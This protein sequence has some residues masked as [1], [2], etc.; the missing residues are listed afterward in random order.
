MKNARPVAIFT[1]LIAA[2]ALLLG[3]VHAQSPTELEW[4]V[5]KFWPE[6]DDPRLLV[7]ID[8]KLANPGDELRLPIPQEAQLNAVAAADDTGR[9]LT[10]DWREE[11]GP[12]GER[13]LVMTPQ[14]PAFRVEYYAP[15]AIDGDRR[16]IDFELPAGFFNAQEGAIEALLPPGSKDVELDPPA[17]DQGPTQDQAQLLQRAL[18][19]VKDQ[20]IRQ[21]ITYAN[22]SG[23][24]TV[25]ETATS[26]GSLLQPT[27]AP[28]EEPPAEPDA[29]TS[30]NPWIL[31][32]G[33]VALLLIAGGVAGLWLTRDTEEDAPPPPPVPKKRQ[34]R[35][36]TVSSRIQP[37]PD[38]L[39]RYCRN[40]GKAFGPDDRFC[41]Y[42]GAKRQTIQ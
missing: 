36:P 20:P 28:V 7:I 27:P 14:F 25:P 39:D 41:R 11:K 12:N 40:C 34:S 15:L 17:D 9:L 35:K 21:K 16:L 5:I 8:G 32:L 26:S 6:Y 4:V 38:N 31:L 42:C 19:E 29:G 22:P 24:L 18:G 1:L 10:N 23:A 3:T 33:V 13:I 37:A 30:M 2:F